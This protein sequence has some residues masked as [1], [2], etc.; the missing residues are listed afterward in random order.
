MTVASLFFKQAAEEAIEKCH[1]SQKSAWEQQP[2]GSWTHNCLQKW[3]YYKIS[4]SGLFCN[5]QLC[6]TDQLWIEAL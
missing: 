3:Q 4:D 2:V 5:Q 1:V 6:Q